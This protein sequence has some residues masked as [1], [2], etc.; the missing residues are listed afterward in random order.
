MSDC[1]VDSG[2]G[3]GMES[4]TF[5]KDSPSL[6]FATYEYLDEYGE[7]PPHNGALRDQL[8]GKL[9]KSITSQGEHM[10]K[11][12]ELTVKVERDDNIKAVQTVSLF[13]YIWLAAD[14][15]YCSLRALASIQ[16]CLKISKLV[17]TPHQHLFK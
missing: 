3:S 8:F 12:T 2:I 13:A 15:Y 1:G 9:A 11:L 4:E 10:K 16:S 17:A 7:V 5:V 6:Q 14:S